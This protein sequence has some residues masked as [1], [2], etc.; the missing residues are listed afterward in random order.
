MSGI[1]DL[2]GSL[3]LREKHH[4]STARRQMT[5]FKLSEIVTDNGGFYFFQNRQSMYSIYYFTSQ[6]TPYVIFKVFQQGTDI[7][8]L[9]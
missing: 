7:C 2:C 1:L 4:K 6:Q 3:Y 5:N 8:P 9:L